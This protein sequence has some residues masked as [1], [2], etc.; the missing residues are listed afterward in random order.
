MTDTTERRVTSRWRTVFD[1]GST[2]AMLALAGVIAWQ[3]RARL[4]GSAKGATLEALVPSEPIAITTSLK[5]G[6]HD[7]KVAIIEFADFEC[8]SC[9]Q[10]NRETEPALVKEYVD[11]GK[12]VLV[13]KNF[14][15]ASHPGAEPAARAAWC[16][17][18]QQKFGELHDWMY[19]LRGLQE[20]DFQFG[21]KQLGLDMSR[22]EAC[23]TSD[24]AKQ[25]VDADRSE[26][27]RLKIPGTPTFFVGKVLSDGRVQVTSSFVG[28]RKIEEVRQ[29]VDKVIGG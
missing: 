18:E 3:G 21:A 5:R 25:S 17:G 10:F 22:Y 23:R 29:I 2:V 6:T 14:P 12:V 13:F 11:T 9:A 19:R 4:S 1:I 8:P 16:A 7:A 28:S 20:S 27:E 24:R 15:L 26:G